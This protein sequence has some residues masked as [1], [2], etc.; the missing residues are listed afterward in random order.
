MSRLPVRSLAALAFLCVGLLLAGCTAPPAP[1]PACTSTI[2]AAGNTLLDCPAGD[3]TFTVFST[4]GFGFTA[5]DAN[6]A[7]WSLVDHDGP[8]APS[9]LTNVPGGPYGELPSVAV[10]ECSGTVTATVRLAHPGIIG[11]GNTDAPS[12]SVTVTQP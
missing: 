1:A 5:L 8:C 10:F 4:V 9:Y 6:A 12:G 7:D 11:I 2:D 3:I